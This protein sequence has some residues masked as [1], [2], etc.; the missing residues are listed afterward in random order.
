MTDPLVIASAVSAALGCGV[1]RLRPGRALAVYPLGAT[2]VIGT[3]LAVLTHG[4]E[5]VAGYTAAALSVAWLTGARLG[6]PRPD[7]A[8]VAP[9]VVIDSEGHTWVATP[10]EQERAA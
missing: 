3:Q 6:R 8:T 9:P 7:R 4:P 2:A 5:G 1:N 10:Q